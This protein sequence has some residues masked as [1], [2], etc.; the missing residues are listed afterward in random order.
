[1]TSTPPRP[2]RPTLRRLL[3]ALPVVLPLLAIGAASA[4]VVPQGQQSQRTVVTAPL[5][6]LSPAGS[7]GETAERLWSDLLSVFGFGG[8]SSQFMRN[9]GAVARGRSQQQDDFAWLMDIAGYK[10]KEIES[11]V[12]LIPTLGLTF[13]QARELTESDRDYV[14]RMLERHARRNPGPMSAIQRTIVRGILDASEIGGFSV[15]KVDV[16]LFPLPKVKFI[17]AP[18]DAPLGIEASRIMRAID[19]LNLRV[20]G[21]TPRSQGLELAPAPR[22]PS[23]SPASFE[24]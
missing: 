24:H 18:T 1:M 13:G 19:R 2:H 12:G 20:Q 3:Q 4:Q 10:L 8:G 5:Q 15:E 22:T 21:M 23:M 7:I 16:D 6:D 14:E 11:S 17:L 9:Y